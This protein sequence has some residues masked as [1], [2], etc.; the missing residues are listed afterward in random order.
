MK[1]DEFIVSG[2]SSRRLMLLDLD[3]TTEYKVRRLADM[4]LGWWPDL[5]GYVIMLSSEGRQIT[6][7]HYRH[8]DG[9]RQ[10]PYVSIGN[11]SNYHVIYDG[12]IPFEKV[13]ERMNVLAELDVIQRRIFTDIAT[14]RN[15]LTLRIGNK[16]AEDKVRGVPQLVTYDSR[17]I[18][19]YQNAFSYAGGTSGKGRSGGIREYLEQLS[20]FLMVVK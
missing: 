10:E 15:S 13:R 4:I 11:R 19:F 18:D 20:T 16:I 5:L 8:F 3:H 9:T 17:G 14:F 2:F 1:A 7:V 6:E 12:Y